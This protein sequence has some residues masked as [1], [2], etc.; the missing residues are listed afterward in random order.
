MFLDNWL[1]KSPSQNQTRG[2]SF[3]DCSSNSKIWTDSKLGKILSN[4]SSKNRL[5][6]HRLRIK[7]RKGVS[8]AGKILTPLPVHSDYK[9]I[10][11]DT[12]KMLSQNTRF[13]GSMHRHDSVRQVAHAP[14]SAIPVVQM[15]AKHPVSRKIG[16][17][18]SSLATPP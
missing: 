1:K 9:I 2:I 8:I 3:K 4:S 11:R 18:N 6:G 10:K 7:R 14:N 13:N 17:N 15:E 16:I 5:P 12:C